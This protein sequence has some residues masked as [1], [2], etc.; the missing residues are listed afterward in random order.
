M[1]IKH[2]K[3]RGVK[4]FLLPEHDKYYLWVD[5]IWLEEDNI[6]PPYNIRLPPLHQLSYTDL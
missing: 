2:R 5:I 6:A 4:D 3:S 1:N